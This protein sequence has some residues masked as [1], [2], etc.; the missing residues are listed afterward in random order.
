MAISGV[1]SSTAAATQLLD[2]LRQA[3][4]KPQATEARAAATPAEE[5]NEP[6]AAPRQAAPAQPVVNSQ[7]QT[8]G[9]IVNTFA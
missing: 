8:T 4:A 7:G 9:R 3:S 2:Q 5:R 1:N 6:T